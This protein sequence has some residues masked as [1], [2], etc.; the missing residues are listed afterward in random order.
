MGNKTGWDAIPS[1]DGLSVDWE[2]QSESSKNKRLSSRIDKQSIEKLFNSR[3][4]PAK[5]ATVD[6]IINCTLD[7]ISSKGVA[8]Y[9][10]ELIL[11][12]DNPVKIGF[13]LG[14]RKIISKGLVKY[15]LNKNN[16]VRVGIEFV[17]L[18]A[19]STEFISE[20]YGAKVL[21]KMM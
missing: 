9:L 16:L 6:K 19:D 13:M 11:T 8:L 17:E 20:L 10:N 7:D 15:I 5:L 3:D 1:L 4:I 14:Q 18:D 21:Q 12:I 2:Y